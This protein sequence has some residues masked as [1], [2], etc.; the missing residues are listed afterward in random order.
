MKL[1]ALDCMPCHGTGEMCLTCEEPEKLCECTEPNFA[2]CPE[3]EGSGEVFPKR[4]K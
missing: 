2:M 4:K 1:K 3:C